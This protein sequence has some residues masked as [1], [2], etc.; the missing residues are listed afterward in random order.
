VAFIDL[1]VAQVV[2]NTCFKKHKPVITACLDKKWLD[3][4]C[5]ENRNGFQVYSKLM[6]KFGT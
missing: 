5:I 3:I 2:L 6:F 1:G 4:N